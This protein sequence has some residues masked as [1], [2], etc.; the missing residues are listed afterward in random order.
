MIKQAGVYE[1]DTDVVRD[2]DYNDKLLHKIS[3]VES[4]IDE[5]D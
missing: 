5:L 2:D 3:Q 4:K 1:K